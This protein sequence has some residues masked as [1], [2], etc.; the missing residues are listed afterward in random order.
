LNKNPFDHSLMN[1]NSSNNFKTL[2]NSVDQIE[3][4][5]L[6]IINQ[7]DINFIPNLFE[8]LN[9]EL[10]KINSTFSDLN[11]SNIKNLQH[12]QE[13]DLSKIKKGNLFS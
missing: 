3:S 5:N 8:K 9:T 13:L 1:E 2:A 12:L 7:S 11:L 6:K 10:K 4:E